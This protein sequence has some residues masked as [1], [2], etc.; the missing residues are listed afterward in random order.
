[1][2]RAKIVKINRILVPIL[3]FAGLIL[4]GVT[5]LLTLYSGTIQAKAEGEKSY[6]I[7]FE[8]ADLK[9]N[10]RCTDIM[11]GVKAQGDGGE[12]LT[13]W[14]RAEI[15]PTDD[16]RLKR[17]C[18]RINKKSYEKKYFERRMILCDSYNGPVLKIKKDTVE[19]SLKKIDTLCEKLL[20]TQ[21][22]TVEDGFGNRSC[23]L[24]ASFGEKKVEKG[25][26][27]VT[28]TA[29]NHLGDTVSK[30]IKVIVT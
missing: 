14:I 7:T 13:K 30:K 11:K 24:T 8:K 22:V 15:K 4:F 6:T 9:Y 18:Y 17:I 19:I 10:S 23:K 26:Y 20:K 3:A 21:A 1:M 12:D 28:V 5:V 16:I 25:V 2:K 27:T 29:E